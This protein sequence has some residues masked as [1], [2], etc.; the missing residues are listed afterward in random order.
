MILIATI[1][2]GR[3]LVA[4]IGA[5]LDKAGLEHRFEVVS[6]LDEI[7]H[8]EDVEVMLTLMV[9]CAAPQFDRMPKLRA[10]VSPLLGYDWIDV[11]EAT[12][13]GIA[14]VNGEV[15]ENRTGMAEATVMLLLALLYRLHDTESALRNNTSSQGIERHL[16]SARTI[17]IFGSGGIARQV[18]A[19][20]APFG[21]RILVSDPYQPADLG[22]VTFVEREELLRNSH[23]ILLL[24]NLSPE[25]R[26]MLGREEFAQVR[27]G[28]IL[29]NTA[30]GGL[31][32]ESALIEA[33]ENGT[34]RAA[35]L[36]V[37]EQ[38][39]L[40]EDHPFRNVPNLILTPHSIGHNEEAKASGPVVAADNLALLAG[41]DLPRSCRNPE[42]KDNR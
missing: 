4:Q 35:A 42:F 37:F 15:E 31:I 17:G 2:P 34:I 24:T 13:R 8:V 16:V 7:E 40:P 32:D 6:S 12:R 3:E 20:L 19:R 9:R 39:P 36:D 23:A 28:T 10:L 22:D 26:H 5:Q 27:P 38:E 14:V 25:T 30:R 29:V 41:G 1:P 11:E 33:M 18:I 21:P